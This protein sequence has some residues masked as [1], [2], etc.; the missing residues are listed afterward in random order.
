MLMNKI[1][2]SRIIHW[3]AAVGLGCG[4]AAFWWL[5]G[6]TQLENPGV[7][8]LLPEAG[9]IYTA[10]LKWFLPSQI[11]AG[12][13]YFSITML[14]ISLCS[15][16]FLIKGAKNSSNEKER[17]NEKVFI[18]FNLVLMVFTIIFSLGHTFLHA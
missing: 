10:T 15:I 5:P 8:H 18:L 13:L 11:K 2:L 17:L 1:N 6:V 3:A 7:P 14:I 12:G 16:F 9:L 4:L